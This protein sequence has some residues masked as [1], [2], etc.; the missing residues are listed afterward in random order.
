LAIARL[1]AKSG[2]SPRIRGAE[3]IENA[4]IPCVAGHPTDAIFLTCDAFGVLPPVSALSPAHAM[5]HFISGYTAKSPAPKW[6]ITEGNV[7]S[8][9]VCG[10]STTPSLDLGP[11]IFGNPQTNNVVC[12]SKGR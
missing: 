4:K 12:V 2:K 8:P 9:D 11:Q 1:E 6:L 3:F 5:Y 7:S 10:S